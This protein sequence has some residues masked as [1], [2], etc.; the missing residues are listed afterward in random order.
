VTIPQE[1][2]AAIS[3][4]EAWPGPEMRRGLPKPA[5][6]SR[7]ATKRSPRAA[8]SGGASQATIARPWSSLATPSMF[9]SVVPSVT[10]WVGLRPPAGLR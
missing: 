6:L 2:S 3:G 5:P 4:G 8:A 7:S 9:T 1:P 10:A